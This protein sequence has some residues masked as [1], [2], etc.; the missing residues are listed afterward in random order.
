[1]PFEKEVFALISLGDCDK[2]S[3]ICSGFFFVWMAVTG[4][5]SL[6]HRHYLF[7][8]NRFV[9]VK[10]LIYLALFYQDICFEF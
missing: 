1:M 7:Y 9:V 8:K 2:C 6:G 10:L 5:M 3:L 4:A